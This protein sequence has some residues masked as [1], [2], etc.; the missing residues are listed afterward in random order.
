MEN[1]LLDVTIQSALMSIGIYFVFSTLNNFIEKKWG[2]KPKNRVETL[3]IILNRAT[4]AIVEV[5]PVFKDFLS[6][7]ENVSK[8]PEPDVTY[9]KMFAEQFSTIIAELK[10][11]IGEIKQTIGVVENGD[12]N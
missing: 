5:L 9:A 1:I 4:S 8:I 6:K 3:D 7:M 11:E 2:I 10:T 12:T